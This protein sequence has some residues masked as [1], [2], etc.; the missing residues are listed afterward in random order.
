LAAGEWRGGGGVGEAEGVGVAGEAARVGVGVRPEARGGVLWRL[1]AAPC[2]VAQVQL[3]LGHYRAAG[4]T[5]LVNTAQSL[6]F[7]FL[8]SSLLL[9]QKYADA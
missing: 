3:G 8:L 5:T 2:N 4:S 7:L 6:I 1:T 9:L